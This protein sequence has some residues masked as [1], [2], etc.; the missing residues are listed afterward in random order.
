MQIFNTYFNK[1]TYNECRCGLEAAEDKEEDA[2]DEDALINDFEL[3]IFLVQDEDAV[4]ECHQG[5]ASA[6]HR[7]DGDERFW[8]GQGIEI[9][10]IGDA[11]EYRNHENGP[12]PLEVTAILG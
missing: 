2:E 12:S 10:D 8:F 9:G 4:E 3:H 5:A 1:K 11:D 7:G 6:Q